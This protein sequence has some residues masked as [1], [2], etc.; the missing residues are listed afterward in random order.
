M[1]FTEEQAQQFQ[2]NLE[3]GKR[4]RAVVVAPENCAIT[5]VSMLAQVKTGKRIR[6]STKPLMNKLESQW[7]EILKLEYPNYARP[8]AQ[9]KTYRLA[10][11]LRYT[12]D[13][14]ATSWPQSNGP[15]IETAWE[16][17]GKWID[18]DSIPKLKMMAASWPEVQLILVWRENG[19]WKQQRI[20]A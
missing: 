14:T 12:P 17:K 11:G 2:D 3:R 18:G 19:V 1:G 13:F 4:K 16:V 10:N 8:R 9:A 6:Q 5:A 7:F 20:L 15:S